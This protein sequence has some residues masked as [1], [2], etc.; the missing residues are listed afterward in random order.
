MK[1]YILGAAIAV[2]AIGCAGAWYT[3]KVLPDVLQAS[4]N[5]A[6]QEL[7]K[8][9]PSLGV[10]G[11]I[12]LTSL[13][14]HFFSSSARYKVRL[15]IPD[16]NGKQV[17][18]ELYFTDKLDHG[19][20]PLSR[21]LRMKLSPVMAESNFE[22][23]SSP[24]LAK[25]FAATNGVAPVSG[26]LSVSYSQAIEGDLRMEKAL[27]TLPDETRI[28]FSGLD[29]RIES[30]AGADRVKS[31]GLMAQLKV[32]APIETGETLHIDMQDLTFSSNLKRGGGDFYFGGTD[33]K[34]ASL[35]FAVDDE[36]PLL[37]K[38][39]GYD[40]QSSEIGNMLSQ[41]DA[42][43]TG[44]ISYQGQDIGTAEA[45]MQVSNIDTS[46]A[47]SLLE[48]Y[49][50]LLK[51][52]Q[53]NSSELTPEQEERLLAEVNKLLAGK[54]MFTL[55]KL[56]LKTANGQAD[57]RL[58]LNLDKPESF[59]LEAP[60][61]TRQL[62]TKLDFN[63]TLSKKLIEDVVGVQA[64][65]AGLTDP[66]AVAQQAKMSSQMAGIMAMSTGLAT[67]NDETISSAL[68]YANGQ[69]TF[70]GKQMPLEQFVVLLMNASSG[71]MGHQP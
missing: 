67:V 44:M 52:D 27:A 29:L 35:S 71:F 57:V 59:E 4:I 56:A 51:Q 12:E 55:E 39:L 13:E 49:G 31:S 22:L 10:N 53:S 38:A 54:P 41:R 43:H 66:Q 68:S 47:K 70:N 19:P 42:Y 21:L 58:S 23:E 40:S 69:V 2:G 36:Q 20:F 34:I 14:T 11:T 17:S 33:G 32:S 16:E 45:V 50:E 62:L 3:G 64:A 6:N 26:N 18:T 5:Q 15:D 30:S 8:S 9:L 25:W 7:A 46:V 65:L 37:I 60:E 28:D 63:F 48:F 1:K 61:L 24:E